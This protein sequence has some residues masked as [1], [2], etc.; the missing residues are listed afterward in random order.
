MMINADIPEFDDYPVP[1]DQR[2]PSEPICN[3]KLLK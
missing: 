2:H 3:M 1:P